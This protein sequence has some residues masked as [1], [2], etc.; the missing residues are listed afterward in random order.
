MG[1]V[2]VVR[3]RAHVWFIDALL[4]LGLAV[5]VV[6]AIGSITPQPADASHL[7]WDSRHLGRMHTASSNEDFC[8]ETSQTTRS[9][10]TIQTNISNALWVDPPS[11]DEKWDAKEWDPIVGNYK[12]WFVAHWSNPCQLMSSSERGPITIEYRAWDNTST[13]CGFNPSSCA[14]GDFLYTDSKGHSA[15]LYYL[16]N[17]YAPYTA[18]EIYPTY[19]RHQVN[20]ETGHAMGLLDGDGTCPVS[21]MHSSAY[22]CTSDRSFPS[23]GDTASE[24][25]RIKN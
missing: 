22:G 8:T 6:L 21:V 10:S 13:P 2:G 16:I 12:V 14:I 15:Y 18:G 24:I 4:G 9:W 25:T 5:G 17:L 7:S 1:F 19:Y 11:A 23:P 20:H 3:T